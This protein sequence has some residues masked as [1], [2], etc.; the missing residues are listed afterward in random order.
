M[1]KDTQTKSESLEKRFTRCVESESKQSKQIL[2]K[3]QEKDKGHCVIIKEM[4]QQ[5]DTKIL[6]IYMH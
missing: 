6:K 3:K 5:E 4:I 1:I 2:C